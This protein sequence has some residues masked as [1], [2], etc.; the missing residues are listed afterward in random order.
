MLQSYEEHTRNERE[1]YM[2][3]QNKI[4][5]DKKS[6]KIKKINGIIENTDNCYPKEE[7]IEIIDDKHHTPLHYEE[8]HISIKR[9]Y[10]KNKQHFNNNRSLSP[11]ILESCKTISNQE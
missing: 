7:T 11:I 1:L 8:E 4:N 5:K 10:T 9:P 3:V 6:T 2:N